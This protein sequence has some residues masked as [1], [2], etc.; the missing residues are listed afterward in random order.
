[1]TSAPFAA[2]LETT[3]QRGRNMPAS[4]RPISFIAT[5]TP[6]AARNFYG[7]TL[8]LSLTEHSPYALVFADGDSTLRVQIVPSLT[9]A[10][11]TVHGWQVTDIA[12]DIAALTA[13]GVTFLRFEHM[14]QDASGIWTTPDGHQIAWFK[15]P[16]GNTLSLTQFTGA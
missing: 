4:R 15:D 2:R 14:P 6:E 1:M 3:A 7:E 5:D 8:G 9:P 10:A 12:A 11:H 13:K 16:C